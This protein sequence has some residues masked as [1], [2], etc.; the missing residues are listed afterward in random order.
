MWKTN[1]I[2]EMKSFLGLFVLCWM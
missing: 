2:A 1:L